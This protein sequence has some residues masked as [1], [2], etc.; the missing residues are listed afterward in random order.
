MDSTLTIY[1]TGA[2]V[3]AQ[4]PTVMQTLYDWLKAHTNYIWSAG[5]EI[6]DSKTGDWHSVPNNRKAELVQKFVLGH[7]VRPSMLTNKKVD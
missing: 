1:S 3:T 5:V 6:C 2:P 7:K 4:E